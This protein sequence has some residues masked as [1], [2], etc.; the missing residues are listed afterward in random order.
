MNQQTESLDAAL[1]EETETY[2]Y[3]YD[4]FLRDFVAVVPQLETSPISIVDLTERECLYVQQTYP[5]RIDRLNRGGFLLS[6]FSYLLEHIEEFDRDKVAVARE[7]V[8]MVSL[9][10]LRAA[11]SLI[12]AA[13]FEG[14]PMPSPDD[15]RAVAEV[16]FE[17]EAKAAKEPDLAS[18]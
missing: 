15:L 6:V 1:P 11:H 16:M 9:S 17:A 18:S 10:L 14:A 7:N 3:P 12:G 4:E 5:D 2:V 8:C 13:H